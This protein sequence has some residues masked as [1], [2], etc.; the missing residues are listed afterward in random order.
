MVLLDR[1]ENQAGEQ[2]GGYRV[3]TRHDGFSSIHPYFVPF[4]Q[5]L[6]LRGSFVPSF[7]TQVGV[8]A[9]W[10]L[11]S[12]T[13]GNPSDRSAS[14]SASHTVR[15]KA[16]R[17]SRV[18]GERGTGSWI[19]SVLYSGRAARTGSST[20][21]PL[22]AVSSS[23]VQRLGRLTTGQGVRQNGLPRNS[24]AKEESVGEGDRA[25]D[26]SE[27]GGAVPHSSIKGRLAPQ[28]LCL[29]A[30]KMIVFRMVTR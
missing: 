17:R 12:F 13:Q 19:R 16:A 10:D 7:L 18:N 24:A 2:A 9:H 22:T 21:A 3:S 6:K 5:Q 11:N 25:G 1:S 30:V 4:H 23:N 27:N 26:S 14:T 15:A 8:P 28:V 29:S 20:E